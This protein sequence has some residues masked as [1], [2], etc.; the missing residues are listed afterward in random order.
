MD[1][2]T[3]AAEENT[4]EKACKADIIKQYI[5]DIIQKTFGWKWIYVQK[6]WYF[7]AGK[8]IPRAQSDKNYSSDLCGNYSVWNL[9]ADAPG[10]FP[11]RNQ[12]RIPPCAFYS[13]LRDLRHGPGTL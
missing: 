3:A 13:D 4:L 1:K 9:P 10:F 2:R 8:G 6:K 7:H 12:L 5:V 11:K